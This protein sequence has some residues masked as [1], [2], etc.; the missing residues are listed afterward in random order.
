M[1]TSTWGPCPD[2]PGDETR[3]WDVVTRGT[4]T[5]QITQNKEMLWRY[6]DAQ[7]AIAGPAN[8]PGVQGAGMTAI[9]SLP[10][11]SPTRTKRNEVKQVT[12]LHSAHAMVAALP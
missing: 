10:N 5:A 6:R 3:R 1:P 4:K 11:P 8:R 7:I 9:I 2:I 12:L